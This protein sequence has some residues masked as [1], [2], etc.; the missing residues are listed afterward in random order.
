MGKDSKTTNKT[1]SVTVP[2]QPQ[3]DDSK[4]PDC[5]GQGIK[6]PTDT[7]V[8]QTCQGTGKA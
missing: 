6:N 4:C 3:A 8:C 7:Y 5:D 1:E 2:T